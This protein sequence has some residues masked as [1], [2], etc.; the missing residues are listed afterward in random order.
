MS[1]LRLAF[2][3]LVIFALW[4]R[5]IPRALEHLRRKYTLSG[6]IDKL[7]DKLETLERGI[8]ER[9]RTRLAIKSLP[10]D[11]RLRLAK[12]PELVRR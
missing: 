8:D 12:L 7:V 4:F 3:L 6:I 1:I 2:S 10:E 9:V 11:L 5:W